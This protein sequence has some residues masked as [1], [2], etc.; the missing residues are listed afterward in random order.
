MRS[1]LKEGLMPALRED[2]PLLRVF[3]RT[4]N[5]MDPPGDLM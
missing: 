3:M 2:L 5:L 1:L 4:M